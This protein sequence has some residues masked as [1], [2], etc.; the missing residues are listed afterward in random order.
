[1]IGLGLG[2]TSGR[3]SVP[4]FLRAGRSQ[5]FITALNEAAATGLALDFQ[6]P[7]YWLRGARQ[8]NF[9]S[10]VSGA[11]YTRTGT[12]AGLDAAVVYAANVPRVAPSSGLRVFGSGTNEARNSTAVGGTVGVIGS[13]GVLPTNWQSIPNGL[14]VEI[15]SIVGEVVRLRYSGT[16]TG[17]F[18]N[19]QYLTGGYAPASPGQIWTGSRY[20]RIV[21]GTLPAAASNQFDIT[22]HRFDSGNNFLG[23]SQSA[24]AFSGST[25]VRGVHTSAALPASTAFLYTAWTVN[26]NNGVP[27]DFTVEI[28]S[29]Q[30]E[31]SSFASD[32]IPNPNTGA[33]SSAGADDV[34]VAASAL[35]TS[36]PILFLADLPAQTYVATTAPRIFEW[37]GQLV[38][39]LPTEINASGG[40]GPPATV[41]GLAAT[42]A[43]RIAMLYTP[44]AATRLSVNGSAVAVGT[45]TGLAIPTGVIFIGN[46]S[47]LDRPLVGSLGVFAAYR[48]TPSDAQLQAMSAL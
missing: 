7:Q 48:A 40:A 6:T 37:S 42:G 10:G 23:L 34:Q 36:G 46:R 38:Q 30:L 5:A 9:A 3:S 18:V 15:V 43:R 47:T 29:P 12:R 41:S 13:G 27:C 4:N 45:D 35:P 33:S 44:G 8:G 14:T 26:V 39:C 31:Q 24:T 25:F 2:I 16:P 21:A 11:T 20:A 28:A 19:I 17:G 32:Y 22:V 1:M